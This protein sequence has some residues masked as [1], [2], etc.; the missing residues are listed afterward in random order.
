MHRKSIL[1]FPIFGVLLKHEYKLALSF[2]PSK[3]RQEFTPQYVL[4]TCFDSIS[5]ELFYSGAI[6]SR[7]STLPRTMP[8]PLCKKLAFF[9]GPVGYQAQLGEYNTTVC[10]RLGQ[11]PLQ[12][13]LTICMLSKFSSCLGGNLQIK[14]VEWTTILGLRLH[15]A[16]F[17]KLSRRGTMYWS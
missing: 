1:I 9:L 15:L 14:W 11:F 6:G 3:C 5:W 12:L 4:Q 17:R 7:D 16:S 10:C 8:W 2:P 13:Q